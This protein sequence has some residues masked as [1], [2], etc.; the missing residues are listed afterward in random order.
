MKK[1]TSYKINELSKSQSSIS[2]AIVWYAYSHKNENSKKI[3]LATRR[4]ME[5]HLPRAIIIKKGR[6]WQM[7]SLS[8]EQAHFCQ[9][10]FECLFS[11]YA[12]SIFFDDRFILE[13]FEMRYWLLVIRSV[14]KEPKSEALRVRCKAASGISTR[15]VSTKQ[16]LTE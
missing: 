10:K 13:R 3:F 9:F 16:Q 4:T 12:I 2:I 7:D 8:V 1:P 14:E 6:G 5:C 15:E 11:N